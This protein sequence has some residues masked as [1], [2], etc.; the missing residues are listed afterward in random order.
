[1]ISTRTPTIHTIINNKSSNQYLVN[2][3]KSGLVLHPSVNL[4]LMLIVLVN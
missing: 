2:T 1:V 4:L 3:Y